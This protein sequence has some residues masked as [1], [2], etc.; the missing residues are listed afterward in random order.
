MSIRHNLSRDKAI[1]LSVEPEITACPLT[2]MASGRFYQS[3]AA[4]PPSYRDFIQLF[5]R[6]V[7]LAALPNV[8]PVR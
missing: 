6:R 1:P 3:F 7:F 2:Q 5:E 8:R 4:L